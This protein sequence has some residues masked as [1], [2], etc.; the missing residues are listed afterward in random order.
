MLVG[1]NVHF[2]A[3]NLREVPHRRLDTLI[4]AAHYDETLFR[5]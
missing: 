4:D 1:M 2:R 5:F 3:G